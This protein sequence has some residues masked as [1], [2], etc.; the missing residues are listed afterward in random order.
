MEDPRAAA[1]IQELKL[2]NDLARTEQLGRVMKTLGIRQEARF[3][4]ADFLKSGVSPFASFVAHQNYD[5]ERM[6]K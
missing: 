5:R 1:R 4:P 2:Q 6:K 3:T